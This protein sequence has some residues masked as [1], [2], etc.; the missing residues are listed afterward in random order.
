[1]LRNPPAIALQWPEAIIALAYRRIIDCW[2]DE[3]IAEYL[4]A[5]EIGDIEAAKR[6]EEGVQ[7]AAFI[8]AENE[9]HNM[10]FGRWLT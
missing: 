7:V 5:I 3:C 10:E 4:R 9:M 2:T 1:M 8:R 6:V